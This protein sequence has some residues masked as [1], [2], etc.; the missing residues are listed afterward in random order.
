MMFSQLIVFW[1]LTSILIL[2]DVVNHTIQIRIYYLP[3]AQF[4]KIEQSFWNLHIRTSQ[5]N[6]QTQ[7][8]TFI[9]SR[10]LDANLGIEN[11]TQQK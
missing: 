11:C 2:I 10:A 1:A 4:M 5:P 3:N 8:E 6:E 9:M 7:H